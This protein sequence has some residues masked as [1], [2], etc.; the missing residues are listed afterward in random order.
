M[1]PFFSTRPFQLKSFVLADM[2]KHHCSNTNTELPSFPLSPFFIL[3]FIRIL[4]LFFI[5][6]TTL[7]TTIITKSPL[8]RTLIPPPLFIGGLSVWGRDYWP[9]KIKTLNLDTGSL[10]HWGW[11]AEVKWMGIRSHVMI[12]REGIKTDPTIRQYWLQ[13]LGLYLTYS[14]TLA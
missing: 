3:V 10:D 13:S 1:L 14:N 7:I 5:I 4:F 2:S 6:I 9:W 11:L 12:R 8:F